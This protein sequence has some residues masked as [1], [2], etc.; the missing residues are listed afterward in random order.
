MPKPPARTP[1]PDPLGAARAAW[2]AL[3]LTEQRR[4]AYEVVASRSEELR[5]A[6]PDLV[7][8]GHGFRVVSETGARTRRGPA[9]PGRLRASGRLT[10]AVCVVFTVE[11]KWRESRTTRA[12]SKSG[13]LPGHLLAFWGHTGPE[14]KEVRV[15]CAVPTDVRCGTVLRA[16]RPRTA[17]I[18]VDDNGPVV[19]QKGMI[20][21]VVRRP[22]TAGVF[23]VSCHHVL[24]MSTRTAPPGRPSSG[25]VAYLR[26]A[27]GGN[28]P[29]IGPLNLDWIGQLT[30]RA[31][32]V[33]FDAALCEPADAAGLVALRE[34]VQGIQPGFTIETPDAVPPVCRFVLA[35]NHVLRGRFVT[36]HLGFDG[37]RYFESAAR[38]PI[39]PSVL[40]FRILGGRSTAGGDSGCVVV[41]EDGTELVGMHL[42]GIDG[43]TTVF[44]LPVYELL[45]P[46]RW[47]QTGAPLQVARAF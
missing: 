13:R 34:A 3:S 6:Y 20:A 31:G 9:S 14:G 33:S 43:T 30:N 23:G 35:G 29:R 44:V 26:T 46:S 16:G 19:D 18:R 36:D 8:V 1:G 21:F 41:S 4:L 5:R 37:I 22:D 40:E 24:A 11:R 10:S 7:A 15:L 32:E 12:R 42:G 27:A 47:G 25:A 38:Q 2:R 39:Q 17:Q 28:G 45:N